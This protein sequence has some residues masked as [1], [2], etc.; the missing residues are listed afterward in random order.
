MSKTIQINT[1]TFILFNVK[2]DLAYVNGDPVLIL[3]GSGCCCGVTWRDADS[4]L[5]D[6]N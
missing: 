5:P 3:V 6:L 2:K 1:P 4:S